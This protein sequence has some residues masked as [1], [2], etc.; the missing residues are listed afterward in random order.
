MKNLI[1][2]HPYNWAVFN[3]Y[4][5]E[6][7]GLTGFRH[8][9]PSSRQSEIGALLAR[10]YWGQGYGQ[11]MLE[12][13]LSFGF[14]HLQLNRI[15]ARVRMD[16]LAANQILQKNDFHLEGTLREAIYNKGSYYNLQIYSILRDEYEKLKKPKC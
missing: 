8:L 3:K 1:Q 13:I 15:Y 4:T 11:E 7:I 2:H 12:V 16:N 9:N 6:F 5:N 10:D 14:A